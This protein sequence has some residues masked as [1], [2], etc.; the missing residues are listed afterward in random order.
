MDDGSKL[1]GDLRQKLLN[2]LFAILVDEP[3]DDE[4]VDDDDD[5]DVK[6]SEIDDKIDIYGLSDFF[7]AYG[8]DECDD[9][10]DEEDSKDSATYG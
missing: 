3:G 2:K 8:D 10:G 5:D 4:H 6:D 1:S 9:D 7:Y